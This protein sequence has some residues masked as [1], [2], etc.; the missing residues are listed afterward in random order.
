[1]HLFII[2]VHCIVIYHPPRSAPYL[3]QPTTKQRQVDNRFTFVAPLLFSLNCILIFFGLNRYV[4]FLTWKRLQFTEHSMYERCIGRENGNSLARYDEEMRRRARRPRPSELRW[5]ACWTKDVGVERR[6]WAERRGADADG[7]LGHQRIRRR[8]NN[9]PSSSP[10][11]RRST[12]TAQLGPRR[13]FYCTTNERREGI[14]IRS[15]KA[16]TM[17]PGKTGNGWRRR[18]RERGRKERRRDR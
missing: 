10:S 15:S 8:T 5:R 4:P 16:S 1:M 17:S 2:S 6:N 12:G 18:R 11:V 13:R 14:S 9:P 7:Y 3:L